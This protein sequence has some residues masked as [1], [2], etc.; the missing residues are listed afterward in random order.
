MS[1]PPTTTSPWRKLIKRPVYMVCR[2]LGQERFQDRLERLAGVRSYDDSRFV[3]CVIW[4]SW[5]EKDIY[6]RKW[7]DRYRYMP[8]EK[9]RFRVPRDYDRIL[10]H[11]YGD[12]MQLPPEEERTGHHYYTAYRK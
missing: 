1:S 8:F 2:L 4:L 6:L 11:T 9:Y 12:Y 5:G 7:F 10:R 3:G